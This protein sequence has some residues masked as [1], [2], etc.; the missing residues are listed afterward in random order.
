M[1]DYGRVFCALW[2]SRDFRS[3][4]E[5]GRALVLY[6]LTCA[7]GT[8]I[9][10]FSLPSLYVCDDIQWTRNRLLDAFAELSRK[11]FATLCE[12]TNWVWIR[13]YLDWNEPD[14]PN[15]WKAAKKLASKIP[16]S[17][18]WDHDFQE[19]FAERAEAAEAEKPTKT[20]NR[21]QT[22][23]KQ[24]TGTGEGSGKGEGTGTG[25][26]EG[27]GGARTSQPVDNSNSTTSTQREGNGEI[28]NGS[29]PGQEPA[30]RN[31]SRDRRNGGFEQ[32]NDDVCKLVTA[33]G[34]VAAD[35]R[36][37][38]RALHISV[39]QAEESVRQLRDRGRLPAVAA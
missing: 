26:G 21:S 16:E 1:R 15:V 4:T 37:I 17:C 29:L 19:Y 18:T 25:K 23:S 13:K 3:L 27:T 20:R 38:A 5:D 36:G 31:G 7:H 34:F 6:L 11:G 30:P 22:V 10:A 33:G 35:T 39:S 9:G 14:N 2:R 12:D 28:L 32:I 24:G 8:M